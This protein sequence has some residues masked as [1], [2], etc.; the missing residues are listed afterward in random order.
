MAKSTLQDES[1]L[2]TPAAAV[3]PFPER[4]GDRPVQ[5]EIGMDAAGFLR[6]LL[7]D[8]EGEP[9]PA[10]VR[11]FDEP[12]GAKSP[13]RSPELLLA[14]C[15]WNAL[16]AKQRESVKSVVRGM[17]YSEPFDPDAVMLNNLLNRRA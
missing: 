16:P 7:L 10:N 13:N 2:A 15:I 4:H 14:L 9:I 8:R 3:L 5:R 11:R 1:T 12:N 17:A 6:L